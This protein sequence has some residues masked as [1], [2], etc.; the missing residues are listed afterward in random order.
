[1]L[2]VF[3]QGFGIAALVVVKVGADLGADGKSGGHRQ[4]DGSHFGKIGT[5]AAEQFTHACV[6][7]GLLAKVEHVFLFGRAAFVNC[8]F[9]GSR[10]LVWLGIINGGV[11]EVRK[12]KTCFG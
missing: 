11:C 12:D 3:A 7:V 10:I 1:M 6:T 9:H 4:A 2:D 5:F 8:L